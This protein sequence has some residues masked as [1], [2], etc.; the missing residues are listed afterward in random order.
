MPGKNNIEGYNFFNFGY[1]IGQTPHQLFEQLRTECD[2]NISDDNVWVTGITGHNVPKHFEVKESRKFIQDYIL[3]LVKLYEKNYG[4]YY[5]ENFKLTLGPCWINLHL[6]NEIIP[7]HNHQGVYSF[8]FWITL[9]NNVKNKEGNFQIVYTN[10]LGQICK[11]SI[12]L[13]KDYEGK[14][15]FFPAPFNHQ[16]LAF[17]SDEKRI[18]IA[19]N[20][21]IKEEK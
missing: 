11:D 4:K 18:S 5:E 6:K 8:V 14:V 20:L 2:K 13:N 21:H 3:E 19:G 7:L 9:P 17:N 16:V 1:F 12:L 10:T 15:I